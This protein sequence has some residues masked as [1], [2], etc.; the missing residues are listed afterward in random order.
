MVYA[1]AVSVSV[2]M[3]FACA[4]HRH[5]VAVLFRG[6]QVSCQVGGGGLG[7]PRYIVVG[8]GALQNSTILL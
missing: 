8:S 4:W 2:G 3:A 6:M 7:W 5:I 1:S